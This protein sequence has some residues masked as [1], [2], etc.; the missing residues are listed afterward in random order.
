LKPKPY[1]VIQSLKRLRF[2][3]SFQ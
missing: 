3:P 1:L 2:W